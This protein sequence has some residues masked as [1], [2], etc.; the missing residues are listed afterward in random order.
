MWINKSDLWSEIRLLVVLVMAFAIPVAV[1]FGDGFGSSEPKAVVVVDED[2]G[3]E[4]LVVKGAMSLRYDQ[5]GRPVCKTG[6][7]SNEQ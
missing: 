7:E 5:N 2:Y 3:C 4:Y 1:F 6:A